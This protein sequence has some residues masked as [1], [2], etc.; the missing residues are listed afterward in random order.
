MGVNIYR[1]LLVFM[2]VCVCSVVSDSLQPYGLQTSRLLLSL[3]FFSK[4]TGM[5]CHFLLQGIFPTQGSNLRLLRRQSD[6][7]PLAPPWRILNR[8]YCREKTFL[9]LDVITDLTT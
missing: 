2:Y 3:E 9:S 1:E 5:G 8:K 6:S 7:L 4:N